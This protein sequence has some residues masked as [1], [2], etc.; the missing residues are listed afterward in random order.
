MTNLAL[1]SVF[2]I[3]GV[4]CRYGIDNL[5]APLNSGFPAHTFLVNIIGCTI[6]GVVVGLTDR[7]TLTGPLQIAIM[8]GFCGGFTTFSAYAVQT[9]TLFLSGKPSVAI[10]YSVLS[11][12]LGLLAVLLALAVTKRLV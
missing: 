11:P 3:F 4:L 8:V 5:V 2:G 10:V 9:A 12:I 1:I 7:G 6:A